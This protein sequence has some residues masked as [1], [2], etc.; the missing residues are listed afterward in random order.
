[1]GTKL[2]IFDMDDVMWDLNAR[3]SQLTG[4]AYNRFTHY[5]AFDNPGFTEEEK[6]AVIRAYTEPDAYRNIVFRKSV[7]DLINRI[8]REHPECATHIVSN[9]GSQAIA[10]A[11]KPQ[12]LDVL[13]LPEYKI[14]LHVIN[15]ETQTKKKKLPDNIFML[16]DDSPHN[17]ILS[18]VQHRIMPARYHND[19]LINGMLDGKLVHRPETD[20]EMT[21]LI[22]QLIEN[23]Q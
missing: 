21:K 14:H 13:E 5:G 17:I 23:T 20:E 11:K 4:I 10:D 9:C 2:V 18:N 22:M 12:L 6:A 16:V 19:V 15:I 3:V 1:M 8:H 7:I